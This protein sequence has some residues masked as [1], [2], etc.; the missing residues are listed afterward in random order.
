MLNLLSDRKGTQCDGST[1]RDFLKA[2]VLGM[3][4]LALSDLLRFRAAASEVG[5]PTRKT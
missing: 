3:G 2:G 1:R 4:G 5:Q